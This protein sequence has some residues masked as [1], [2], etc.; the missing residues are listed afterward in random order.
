MTLHGTK[1]W[2]ALALVAALAVTL[3]PATGRSDE[4]HVLLFLIELARPQ[5]PSPSK[6]CCPQ[7]RSGCSCPFCSP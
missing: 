7:G 2:L 1:K 3:S 4:N 5:K 6:P